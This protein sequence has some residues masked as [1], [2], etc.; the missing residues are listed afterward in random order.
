MSCP[1]NT[2]SDSACS[3]M[4]WGH[5]NGWGEM[6]FPSSSITE[7]MHQKPCSEKQS[8]LDWGKHVGEKDISWWSTAFPKAST[9]RVQSSAARNL[10]NFLQ[11]LKDIRKI[12]LKLNS[13]PVQLFTLFLIVCGLK[14]CFS[15]ELIEKLKN[16]QI[17]MEIPM[18]SNLVSA[19][20]SPRI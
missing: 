10:M 20:Q 17:S 12:N 2:A 6:C 14:F 4:L 16:N 1:G 5:S 7:A 9:L 3:Q 11:G 18:Q 13:Y 19:V 15:Q 8:T